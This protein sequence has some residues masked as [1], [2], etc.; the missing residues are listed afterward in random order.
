MQEPCRGRAA[1][2][3]HLERLDDEMAIVDGT[4]GPADQEPRVE[5]EN[6]REI[7]LPTA[8]DHEL[9]RVADPAL[10][11]CGG[12]EVLR[13]HIRR[14][15]QIVIAHRRA[16]KTLP[17]PRGEAFPLFQP[18][19]PLPTDAMPLLEQVAMNPWTAIG[20]ATYLMRRANQHAQL[21]VALGMRR[22][23]PG[24]PRVE[25]TQRHVQRPTELRDRKTGLLRSNP[26]KLHAWCFAK[27]AAAFFR[28]SRSV[29]SSRFSLRR[30]R[31][32]SRASV[33]KPV[34]PFVRSA[35]P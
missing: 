27:K 25:A 19:Y 29:R 13:E 10:V 22:F 4:D 12:D 20:A 28:I 23:G 24:V 18:N 8:A 1:L 2:Q 31:S 32:S 5:I 30:R 3:G 14:D 34:R 9:G 21:L 26:G 6:R 15:R 16:P 11:R 35:R 7:E 17:R 33:V